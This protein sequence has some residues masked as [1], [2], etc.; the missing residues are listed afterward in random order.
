MRT[1]VQIQNLKCSGCEAT[2]KKQLSKLDHLNKV[3]VNHEDETVSF[4]FK[5]ESDI[6]KVKESLAKLGYPLVGEKNRFD[7]KA[8]SYVS[9]AVG[10]INK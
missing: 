4:D 7:I 1:S 2:I 8:K 3:V 6:V 10:R 5:D 9:C